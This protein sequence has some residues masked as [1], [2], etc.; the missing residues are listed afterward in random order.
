[1]KTRALLL[2][3]ALLLLPALHAGAEDAPRTDAA[4]DIELPDPKEI[5]ATPEE[6][7]GTLPENLGAPVGTVVGD[8]EIGTAE[9]GTAKLSDL[10]AARPLVVFF[11]RGGWCPYCNF[12]VREFQRNY[13]FFDAAGVGVVAISVDRPDRSLAVKKAYEISFP[14]LSDPDLKAHDAFNSAV[15]V[16]FGMRV[17][18]R[19]FGLNIEEWSGREH[20]KIAVPGV[21]LVDRSRTVQWAH[22]DMDYAR[23]PSALHVLGA[24]KTWIKQTATE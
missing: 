2:A 5:D 22:A 12:Q 21:Y 6:L 16:G 7:L 15:E 23:R 14:V 4:P 8:F 18:Y 20:H 19:T 17:L 11:Y 10:L 1:M 13:E 3:F 9:G 24:V